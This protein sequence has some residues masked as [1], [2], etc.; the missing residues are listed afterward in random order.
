MDRLLRD[1]LGPLFNAHGVSSPPR[2]HHIVFSQMNSVLQASAFDFPGLIVSRVALGV[3]EAG[4]SPALPLYLC[5]Y[6]LPLTDAGA[7]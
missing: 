6:S 2:V 7:P 5:E 1:L 3:F 4:F